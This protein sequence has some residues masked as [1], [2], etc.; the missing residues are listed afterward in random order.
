M[1]HTDA[2][3]DLGQ[4]LGWGLRYSA[5]LLWVAR[6]MRRLCL[7]DLLAESHFGWSEYSLAITRRHLSWLTH[8]GLPLVFVVIFA[9]RYHD[10]AWDNSLG[11]IAFIGAMLLLA[12]FMHAVLFSK[13][14][15]LREL[16]ARKPDL[17]VA[18]FWF[19]LYAL[20][21]G[22]PSSLALL[23]GVGY[24]YSAQ[25]LALR[26]ETTLGLV[27]GFVLLHAV[28]SPLVSGE[29]SQPGYR[30]DEGPTI[31]GSREP[32]KGCPGRAGRRSPTGSLD[33]SSAPAV[34]AL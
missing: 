27:L 24:Y 15:V 8:G 21:I 10:G 20:A 30:T 14:N 6:F 25:Q 2:V 18:R 16:L 17:W 11:R 9:G 22:L 19:V 26:L 31:A 7:P 4:A 3:S 32:A 29:T 33:D 13:N 5:L 34:P 23:A 12:V 28:V 1:G